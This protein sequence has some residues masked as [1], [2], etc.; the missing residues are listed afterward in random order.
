M[1]QMLDARYQISSDKIL[2]RDS[3]PKQ[4]ELL[5]LLL[6]TYQKLIIGLL[7]KVLNTLTAVPS[8]VWARQD[9]ALGA[10]VA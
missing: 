10:I 8:C 1:K 3:S 6:V 5:L 7:L 9:V 2:I 4:C